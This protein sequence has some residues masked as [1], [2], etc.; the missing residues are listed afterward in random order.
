MDFM[1]NIFGAF[2][3]A[4]C[5]KF[6]EL[7]RDDMENYEPLDLLN[8][9]FC[10]A[11]NSYKENEIKLLAMLIKRMTKKKKL[12]LEQKELIQKKRYQK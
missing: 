4:I 2:E 8:L 11:E 9:F 5:S 10:Y 3:C 6:M 12:E 1:N 7:Y